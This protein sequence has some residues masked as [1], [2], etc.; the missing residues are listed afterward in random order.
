M[1]EEGGWIVLQ[2]KKKNWHCLSP[3]CDKQES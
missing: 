3:A 1:G 2:G